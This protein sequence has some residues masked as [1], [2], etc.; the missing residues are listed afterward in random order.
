MRIAPKTAHEPVPPLEMET[1]K[2]L[3]GMRVLDFT[4]MKFGPFATQILGDV[5]ADIIKVEKPS[6]EWERGLT[7]QGTLVGDVSPFFLAMNRNKRS[8]ALDLKAPGGAET[9]RRLA[10]TCDVVVSNFRPG[11]MDRLGMGYEALSQ[12][13]PDIIVVEGSGWGFAG[14]YVDR[15]G[16]DLLVQAVA[17]VAASTGMADLPPIPTA[18]SIADTFGALYMAIAI[19]VAY[20]YRMRTGQGQLVRL[21]LLDSLIAVQCEEAVAWLNL[22]GLV[23]RP[24]GV[25]GAP[26]HGAP[27]GVYRLRDG[28][29]AVAMNDLGVLARILDVP[30]LAAYREG[31][32]AF[33]ERAAATALIQGRLAECDLSMLDILLADDVWAAK[34][35]TLPEALTDP[36]VAAS[37]MIFEVEDPR[38]GT[39]A[40][41]GQPIRFARSPAVCDRLAPSIGQ[42]SVEILTESGFSE[43]EIAA[44]QQTGTIV[45]GGRPA[46]RG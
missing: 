14:P 44:L 18:L 36:Q 38:Y 31:G 33:S 20:A 32:R 15:P 13:K 37:G 43:E 23:E 17:G 11:V 29:L 3:A 7:Y 40:L 10:Q 46:A 45:D 26:W 1:E 24:Q 4:Q 35:N 16:Q 34:V 42:Q 5:G 28:Y 30:E 39:M 25:P 9:A 27:F 6:G 12:L 22:G 8:I 41:I 21:N 19:L 2:A